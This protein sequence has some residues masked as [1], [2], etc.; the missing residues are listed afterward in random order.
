MAQV[1]LSRRL[2][3]EDG[4]QLVE[5]AIVLP[6]LLLVVL[7]IAEFGFIFQRFEVLTNAAREGARMAVLPGYSNTDIE[8]RVVAYATA[9]GVPDFTVDNVEITDQTVPLA[10][11]PGMPCKRVEITFTH[12]YM[13]MGGIGSLFG[14]TYSTV[15]L[16]AVAEMRVEQP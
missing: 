1:K 16:R 3:S 6:L 2:D 11:G 9:G 8:N 13:F 7:S 10:V 4:A 14:Q 12:S 15:P 5:F